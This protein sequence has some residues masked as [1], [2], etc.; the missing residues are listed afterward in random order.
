MVMRKSVEG[1][2]LNE[3]E[4]IER[5]ID[6]DLSAFEELVRAHQQ[7]A[8]RVAYV[9]L[10]DSDEAQDVTQEAFVKAH[11]A[12]GR[13]RRESPFRPWLLR[14][15]RNEALNRRRRRGRQD[16]LALRVVNEEATGG[17]AP[18]PE[19][20]LLVDESRR[21]VLDAVE[22]LPTRY[23]NVIVH[24]FLLE[25]SEAETARTLGVP[26]GTVK[27]RVHRGLARLRA[28]MREVDDE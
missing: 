26:A 5:T 10:G 16:R 11:R 24:R 2:P 15:V 28:M 12:L 13:F 4:L 19:A 20:S 23:R 9:V 7:V 8:L 1:R 18:S 21:Q 14:I 3:A 27:S 17:A 25:L 22:R 6:G